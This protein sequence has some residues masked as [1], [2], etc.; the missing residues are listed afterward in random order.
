MRTKNPLL[1]LFC[2]LNIFT[3]SSCNSTDIESQTIN[4]IYTMSDTVYSS[5]A[6]TNNFLD[7]TSY[8]AEINSPEMEETPLQTTSVEYVEQLVSSVE[9]PQIDINENSTP[10][11]I[12]Q[13]GRTAA[14][15]FAE[16]TEKYFGYGIENLWKLSYK[17]DD[18]FDNGERTSYQ[19]AG[20]YRKS[21]GLYAGTKDT[22]VP[23]NGEESKQFLIDYIGLTEKGYEELCENSPSTYM[24]KDG[25]FYVSSGDG[26]QAGWD[27]CRIISYEMKDNTVT[28]NCEIEGRAETWGYDEDKVW[29]FTFR[30]A[31]EDSMWKLDGISRSEDFFLLKW[32][33]TD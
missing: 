5:V 2:F 22:Y 7:E 28:Y 8:N 18:I 24:I 16:T 33:G 10:E 14:I 29:S 11:E 27:Y 1:L 26:G 17:D 32:L 19:T 23:M 31:K 9:F 20:A 30:L 4:S 13:A 15:F 6:T 25:E 12:M 3:L 21:L